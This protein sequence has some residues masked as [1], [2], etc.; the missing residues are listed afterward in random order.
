MRSVIISSLLLFGCA[1]SMLQ[2]DEAS[3]CERIN[4]PD[5]LGLSC[6]SDPDGGVIIEP[7]TGVFAGLSS[8]SLVPLDQATDPL[9]FDQPG[10]WLTEQAAVDLRFLGD[11]L[12]NLGDDPDNPLGNDALD[13]LV[14]MAVDALGDLREVSLSACEDPTP[15]KA[16]RT[17]MSCTYALGPLEYL[18]FSRVVVLG[19]D[20]F[21]LR[22]RTMN[23]QRLG[24]LTAIANSFE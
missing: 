8:L 16:N 17:D 21:A 1:P 6:A 24:H 14:T 13:S 23:T 18:T 22:G 5:G 12:E 4:V 11:R 15:A 2:A 7:E 19:D 9:A 10:E 20:R 3:L